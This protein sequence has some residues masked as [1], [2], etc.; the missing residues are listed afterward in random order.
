METELLKITRRLT[1]RVRHMMVERGIN[2]AAELKRRLAA[3][4]YQITDS[5]TTRLVNER[6]I[7]V[8]TEFL[9][10]LIE[11]L[12]CEIQDILRAELLD[13]SPPSSDATAATAS[14]TTKPSKAAARR[15]APTKG[16]KAALPPKM[17]PP[18]IALVPTSLTKSKKADR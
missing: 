9:D 6:P 1:W 3:I 4:G 14:G 7:E 17:S 18:K 8:K 2:S 16:A 10:A 12:K 15:R 5:Q 11:V 13:P